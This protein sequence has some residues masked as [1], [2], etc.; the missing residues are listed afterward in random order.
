MLFGSCNFL[1][2][3]AANIMMTPKP[4]A[5][6]GVRNGITL[7][8]QGAISP[9]APTISDKPI[10]RVSGI[11]RSITP[12]CFVSMNFCLEKVDLAKPIIKKVAANNIWAIHNAVFI[13]YILCKALQTTAFNI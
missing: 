3:N 7:S 9:I 5:A 6:N 2:R 13:K 1:W 8:I 12:V 11:G 10:N 4:E